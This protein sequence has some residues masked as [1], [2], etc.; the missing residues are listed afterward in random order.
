MNKAKGLIFIILGII[1]GAYN[2]TF[3]AANLTSSAVMQL[4][5]SD[6]L[7]GIGS[8][9]ATENTGAFLSVVAII[10]IA[11]GLTYYFKQERKNNGKSN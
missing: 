10:L 1:A 11:I 6:I 2:F 7:Y 9:L 4:E 5:D 3:R 8:R